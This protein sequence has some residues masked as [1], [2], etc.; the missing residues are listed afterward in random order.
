MP[1][2]RRYDHFTLA[3]GIQQFLVQAAGIIQQYLI[4]AHK[5]QHWRK[6]GQITEERRNQWLL[7]GGQPTGVTIGI[8]AQQLFGQGW[9]RFAVF[10]IGFPGAGQ[11]RPGRN[12]NEP[13]G[14]RHVHLL[15]PQAQRANEPASGAFPAQHNLLR[16]IA[17]LQQ[18]AVG[19]QGILHSGWVGAFRG[20]AVGGAEYSDPAFISQRRAE[21]LSV[22]QVAAGIAAAMQVQDHPAAALIPRDQPGAFKA[23][24]RIIPHND[25]F[26]VDRF[27]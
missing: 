7:L 5:K 12:G 16:R 27:H 9:V 6:T 8:K 23:L 24:K 25:I 13:R 1:A 4:P 3:A 15:Q 18:V 19:L 14:H 10:L 20:Q 26:F 21:A 22:V 17:F 11:I 2:F